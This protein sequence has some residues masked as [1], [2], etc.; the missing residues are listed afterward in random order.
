MSGARLSVDLGRFRANLRE[1]RR[2]AAPAEAMLVVKCDAYGHGLDR[3]VAAAA[4]EGVRWFGAFDSA[5]AVRVRKVTGDG[6]RIFA[7]V[8]MTDDELTRAAQASVT[9]GV[10]DAGYLE[11]I[12]AVSRG[13]AMPVHLK[14]DTGLHRSGIRPEAWGGFV[15]RAAELE[16]AGEIR[17]DG[18]WSHIAEVSD[19]DDDIA[20]A[21]FRDAVSIAEAAGLTPAVRH[22]AASAAGAARPGFRFD[23]VRFG[24]FA[25]G[26]RS[27][28]AP[29]PDGIVPAATLLAPVIEIGERAVTVGVGTLDGLPATLAG[30]FD[31]G[32]PA[33]PRRL[34][35]I[36]R[37]TS[38]VRPWPGVAIGDEVAVWGPGALGEP[39]PTDLAETIGTVG[40]EVMVRL[41][42]LVPREYRVRRP[43]GRG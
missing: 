25:Y 34:L 15:T 30:C 26:I 21:A 24:A 27:A 33:G 38:T 14:I 32:T 40:E 3:M 10:G 1:L 42:P 19:R 6:A 17:V 43:P 7:W 4:A 9:L 41:S 20:R 23:L 39:S 2:R 11:R 37:V 5:T 18:V 36:D 16:A 35:R 13:R 12:A 31:V 29:S 8:T 22:L 28:G